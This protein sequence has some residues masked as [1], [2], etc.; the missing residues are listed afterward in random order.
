MKKNQGLTLIELIVVVAIIGV[1][2]AIAVPSLNALLGYEAQRATEKITASL[3]STRVEA[4]SRL[5]G[6]MKLY[7]DAGGGY[8]VKQYYHDGSKIVESDAETVAGKKADIMYTI[9]ETDWLPIDETG[10]MITYDRASGEFR[11]IQTQTAVVA[12]DLTVAFY[13]DTDYCMGIKIVGGVRTRIIQ[14][15]PAV[16]TY[17]V[18]KGA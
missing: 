8:K 6:E 14:L 16:G 18:A 1:L 11:P 5:T 10:I 13:D 12:D 15:H 9:N 17:E 3:D 4:M 7:R 2:L